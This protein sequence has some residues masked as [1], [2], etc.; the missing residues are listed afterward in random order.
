MVLTELRQITDLS[1]R[2]L[3]DQAMGAMGL[4]AHAEALAAAG[5]RDADTR[6]RSFYI[7][8]LMFVFVS[9]EIWV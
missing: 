9:K 6:V 1:I 2:L 7:Q 8:L 3:K 4:S 5:D